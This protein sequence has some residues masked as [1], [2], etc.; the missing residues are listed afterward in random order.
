MELIN[1]IMRL[2]CNT[3]FM[4]STWLFPQLE[5]MSEILIVSML[6]IRFHVYKLQW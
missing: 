3:N 4:N 6:E 5:E 1:P 2:F